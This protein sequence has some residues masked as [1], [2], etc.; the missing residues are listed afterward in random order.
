MITNWWGTY[1][2]STCVKSC[3]TGAAE[4]ASSFS[5]ESEAASALAFQTD[6]TTIFLY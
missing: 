6:P 5:F 1:A 4:L 2:R 3:R